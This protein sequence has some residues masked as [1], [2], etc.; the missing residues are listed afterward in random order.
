MDNLFEIRALNN[1]FWGH[2]QMMF[3]FSEMCLEMSMT[4]IQGIMK[5][6]CSLCDIILGQQGVGGGYRLPG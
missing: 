6:S 3:K 5:E 4:A 2:L 1:Y